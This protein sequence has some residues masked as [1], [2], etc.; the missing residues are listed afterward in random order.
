ME[1]DRSSGP[2]PSGTLGGP[3]AS[4][5]R[6]WVLYVD[7]DAFY[8][9]CELRDRHELVGSPVIVGPDPSKG[10]T[11]G[12]VLSASY[13][14][15]AKGVHSAMPAA[16][17]ARLCPEATWIG[18]DF[19]K[20]V[21]VSREF[22][23]VLS[24][25]PGRVVAYSI[26][27]AALLVEAMTPEDAEHLARKLQEEIRREVGVPASIGVAPFRVVAKIATDRAKPGGV[28]VV[29]FNE[30][31][32][33]LAPLPVR[34]IPGVG[35]KTEAVLLA[36]GIERIGDLADG[37]DSA[38]RRRLGGFADALVAL[39]RGEPMEAPEEPE[40]GPRS[41]STDRTFASDV[42]DLAMLE[43]AVHDLAED[44]AASLEKEGLRY[45][46]VTVAVRWSDFTRVQR[47]RSMSARVE[48]PEALVSGAHRLLHEIWA[49]EQGGR[50]RSVRLVS[51]RAERLEEKDDRQLRLDRFGDAAPDR[52]VM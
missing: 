52:T 29:P 18:A 24:R 22:R 39:A 31:E 35:P 6:G 15:R 43:S 26:D 20:Y 5:P 25:H 9:S 44:L 32:G 38:L 50:R 14:A 19:E 13:E 10:P 46:T 28:L 40:T 27:E 16:Q 21:R 47:G 2:A 7:L 23:S 41:R 4:S 36:A 48:G 51:V 42:A 33:F 37:A 11:R 8:V 17:A 12:V 1:G 34:S 3:V 30:V 49:E 45:R